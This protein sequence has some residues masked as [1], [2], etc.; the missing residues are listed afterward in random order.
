MKKIL[1]AVDFSESCTNAIAYIRHLTS[2]SK[3]KVD[4]MHMYSVPVVSL[5]N[6]PAETV[7][8]VMNSK[9]KES[10]ELMIEQMNI[11][12]SQNRGEIHLVY[13]VYPSSEIIEVAKSIEPDLIVMALR[14]K[15]SMIYRLLGTVT[16]NT[17]YKTTIPLLAI[18]NGASFSNSCHVLHPTEEKHAQTLT[19]NLADQLEKLVDFCSIFKESSISMIHINK[20]AGLDVVYKNKPLGD[21]E[22]IVSQAKTIHEGIKAALEKKEVD[23]IAIQKS[24]RNFWERLYHSSLTRKILFNAKLPIL[25]LTHNPN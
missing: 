14:Q 22:L 1:I 20:G 12:E 16:A 15:Y 25:I 4:M 8:Q 13:G 23:I 24:S 17:M 19:D 7:Q 10:Q 11:L 18:P 2:G 9:K 3:I 6:L 21:I 5:T